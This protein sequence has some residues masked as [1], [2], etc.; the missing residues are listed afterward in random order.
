MKSSSRRHDTVSGRSV[1][2]L[3]RRPFG[4]RSGIKAAESEVHRLKNIKYHKCYRQPAAVLI[5]AGMVIILA[6]CGH[7]ETVSTGA[8]VQIVE[9]S[10]TVDSTAAQDAESE[11]DAAAQDGAEAEDNTDEQDSAKPVQ[12]DTVEA[13][14]EM[15]DETR[16]QLTAELLEENEMDVSVVESGRSTK[17]C[18]FEIPEG[19]EESQDADGLYVTAR[20]PLDTSMI[21]YETL[22]GDISLQL[23]TEEQFKEQAEELFYLQYGEKIKLDI[24]S[25]EDVKVDGYP[26]FRI[27]CHYE[28]D[29]IRITQLE[30]LI[31]ADKTY[32]ITY[33]QTSDYDW[34]EA[35]EA[36]A[37]TIHVK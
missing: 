21:Y 1:S 33:S 29:N 11:N 13:Q 36:S 3:R 12:N 23:M 22:D 28:A 35:Y 8:G 6:G 24:D 9:S 26:A 10:D 34:M 30:Y 2:C 7:E 25:F 32:V 17:G 15:D 37:A 18:T 27:M 31:N 16:Q 5:V 19:F 4:I 20:Y 14:I